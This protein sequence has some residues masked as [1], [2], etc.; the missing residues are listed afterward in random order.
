MNDMILLIEP[1]IPALR[2]YARAH[3]GDPA[4]ADDLVQASLECAV[5]RWHQ[6]REDG[7]ARAWMFAI[8][9]N[10]AI[11]RVRQKLRRGRHVSIDDANEA[12]L[13]RPAW[14]ESRLRHRDLLQAMESLSEDQKSVLLLVSIEDPSYAE[15]A[16]VLGVPIG[17][18]MSRLARAREKLREAMEGVETEP[19]SD[20]GTRELRRIQ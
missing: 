1:L 14:Q 7:D 9:H 12:S 13:A 10:L 20:E 6:R 15:A 3:V 5:S 2:R 16:R 17:T 4:A 19:A 18:V 11:S 8:L